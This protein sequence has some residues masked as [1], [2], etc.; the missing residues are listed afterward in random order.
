MQP[1]GILLSP[2]NTNSVKQISKISST[3]HTLY[4]PSWVP[5]YLGYICCSGHRG[6]AKKM[7]TTLIFF[8]LF[9]FFSQIGRFLVF[10]SEW[11]TIGVR[12]YQ[13]FSPLTTMCHLNFGSSGP[14]LFLCCSCQPFSDGLW[15]LG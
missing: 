14:G 12:W 3:V 10:T 9:H 13:K 1:K 6:G 15:P 8:D 2:Q 4:H 7:P 5:L 11:E